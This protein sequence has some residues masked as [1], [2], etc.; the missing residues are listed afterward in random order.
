VIGG[1]R[2]NAC[3][4]RYFQQFWLAGS[5]IWILTRQRYLSPRA[6]TF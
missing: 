4:E 1:G 3:P 2:S 5:A 6:I